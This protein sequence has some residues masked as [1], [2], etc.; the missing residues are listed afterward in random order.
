LFIRPKDYIS[1]DD[2]LFFAVVSEYQE[3]DRALTWLR[4]IKDGHGLNKIETEQA[5]KLISDSYPEF[6]FHSQYADS[7]LHGIPLE[8]IGHVYRPD[9]TVV[10]LL[11][12]TDPDNKQ[13]DAIEILKLLFEVGI[14]EENIGVTGSIMLD[15]HNEQSDIDIVIYGRELFYKVRQTIKD[16][17]ESGKLEPLGGSFWKDAYQRRGCEISFQDYSLHEKRKFNKCIS[18]TSKVDISMIPEV[19]ERFQENGPF[20]KQGQ[21]KIA[22]IVTDDSYAYDFPARYFT[23]HK[24][25][26]EVVSYT[27]TYVGQVQKGE[28]IE[29]AG[30]V[31]QGSD[32][33]NRILVGTSR[34]AAGE[35]IRLVG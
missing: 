29:A 19:Y 25:I 28:K 17:L 35:Y 7:D 4:Y 33:K 11:N 27:A 3:D 13:R 23:D 9:Q 15:T 31:E 6:L 26:S 24:T 22:A 16:Y 8:S 18:G 2:K 21:D 30:Y 34:E 5:R 10:R 32:G 20:K 1:I 14:K 12:M